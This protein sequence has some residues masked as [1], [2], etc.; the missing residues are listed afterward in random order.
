[1]DCIREIMA[2]HAMRTVLESSIK[3]ERVLGVSFALGD[4]EKVPLVFFP[5]FIREFYGKGW[6]HV[7]SERWC[8]DLDIL[9]PSFQGMFGGRELR[10]LH[11][12]FQITPQNSH[13]ST[14]PCSRNAN[15]SYHI[16]TI[17]CHEL[18]TT[19]HPSTHLAP[20]IPLP[21]P[22]IPLKVYNA[23]NH[24]RSD[25]SHRKHLMNIQI[26][27]CNSRYKCEAQVKAT[28]SRESQASVYQTSNI[29][30]K[31]WRLFL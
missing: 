17:H 11:F 10:K 28:L 3:R 4:S 5:N 25:R 18:S 7:V 6:T 15:N 13:L 30:G 20:G 27:Q 23:P 1:M 31:Q 16:K 24:S 19:P 9:P 14:M 26:Q 21:T 29:R 12:F 22:I 8:L 2:E